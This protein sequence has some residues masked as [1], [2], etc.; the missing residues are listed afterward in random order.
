[1]IE[2]WGNTNQIPWKKR[3]LTNITVKKERINLKNNGVK[4]ALYWNV[5][6]LGCCCAYRAYSVPDKVL[7]HETFVVSRCIKFPFLMSNDIEIGPCRTK[8]MWRGQ[9]IYPFV[10]G[11]IL[12]NELHKGGRAYMIVDSS[13]VSSIKGVKKAGFKKIGELKKT[14]VFKKYSLINA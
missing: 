12:Q 9:G 1:M 14:G 10:L 8:E 5:L 2:L 7:I 4:K 3:F 11:I 13:N 6:S